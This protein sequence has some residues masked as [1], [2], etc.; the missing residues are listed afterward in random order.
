MNN[1]PTHHR[2]AHVLIDQAAV[3][4]NL[5]RV[6]ALCPQAQIMAVVKA[7]G[8]GHGM[9]VIVDALHQA[10]L[11]GVNGLDDVLRLRDYGVDK[12]LCILSAGFDLVILQQI[13]EQGAEVVV[14]DHAQLAPLQQLPSNCQLDV[15]IKVDTGMGRLGFSP[16]ELPSVYR[17]LRAVP[18]LR[19]IMLMSHLANADVAADPVN[20][21][22]IEVFEA[23]AKSAKFDAHSVLNSAGISGFAEH[24]HDVVRPGIM[25]YGISPLR[26]VLAADL[27]LRPAM[28][29]KSELISVKPLVAGSH[30]GYGAGYTLDRD[31]RIGVVACGYGDGYPRHAKNGTPVLVNGQ[32]VPLIGRVSM[33]MLTV[34]LGEMPAQV[35]DEVVLWGADNPIETVADAAQTIAYE[36]CCGILPRVKRTTV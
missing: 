32:V 13:A 27:G 6:R 11:F 19:K 35:G 26:G 7:D 34:D 3:Q 2:P 23:L 15:W 21:K 20:R 4:Q 30:V 29:F 17:Q 16:Q 12:P 24:A 5:S 1:Q 8:Y 25:L 14:F 33:D 18:A 10:D 36:L 22:Q 31:S 28:T 9:E